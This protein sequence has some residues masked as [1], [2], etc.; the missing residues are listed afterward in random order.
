MKFTRCTIMI[1]VALLLG[2]LLTACGGGEEPTPMP[3]MPPPTEEPVLEATAVPTEEPAPTEEPTAVPTPEPTK[4]PAPVDDFVEFTAEAEGVALGYPADWVYDDTFFLI[5]A[6]SEELMME[7]EPDEDSEGA[8][9][10]VIAGDAADFDDSDPMVAINQTLT[11]FGMDDA[12]SVREGPTAVTINGQEGAAI[13]VDNVSDGGIPMVTYAVLLT[14]NERAAIFIGT[15]PAKDEAEYLYT[16]KAMAETIVIGEPTAVEDP[17]IGDDIAFDFDDSQGLLW[18]GDTENSNISG[19][20]ASIWNFIGTEGEILDVRVVP[21]GDLDVIVD[22]FDEDGASILDFPVDDSFGTEEII[23][24]EIPSSGIYYVVI[25][26]FGGSSGAYAVTMVE[27]GMLGDDNGLDIG[28]GAT[29]GRA[30]YGEIY[31]GSHNGDE[32]GIWTF[33]GQAGEFADI[34]V[35]PQ[36]EGFDVTLDVLDP[37]GDSML[38]DIL[39]ASFDTEYIRLLP[40]PEDGVYTLVVASYDGSPGD[41]EL[42]IK[43]SD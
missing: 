12:D 8:M 30:V 23:G 7:M 27:T 9:V 16:L 36:T 29:G 41:Y 24:L 11:E 32:A 13:I 43:E 3:E 35:S 5:F 40:L 28:G 26:S 37:A 38:D 18:Y 6:S 20:A 17:D 2:V 39:D 25:T 4:E 10:M 1:V 34:T 22:V 42:L 15:T 14:N 31:A 33:T 21:A 19:D